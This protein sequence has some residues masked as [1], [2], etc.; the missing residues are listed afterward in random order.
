MGTPATG[1]LDGESMD[2]PAGT[3]D[4]TAVDPLSD[5]DTL[6]EMVDVGKRYGSELAVENVSLSVVDGE[7]LTL[8]GPSGCGKTT[9]L[10]LI[11]GL[12]RP[13]S[14]TIRID[15]DRVAGDGTFHPPERRGV[16]VVFQGFA[17]FP[18]LTAEENVA[19]GLDGWS[20]PDRRRRVEELFDLVD[21]S[22]HRDDYPS[23]LSGGQQ[24]RVAL[25]RSLAPE[26]DVL[27]LDEPFSNLDVDLRIRMREQVRRILTE[28]GTTAISV[29]HD[30]EEALSISDRVAVMHDGAIEQVD[31][32]ESLYHRPRSRFVAEFLGETSFLTGY[33]HGD[34]VATPLE[35]LPRDRLHGLDP[36]YDETHIDVLIRPDDVLATA[37]TPEP[38]N[39]T[40]TYRQYRGSTVVFR[41]ELDDGGRIECLHN[42]VDPLELGD[43]VR[44]EL[45]AEHDLAWF[46]AGT[47]DDHVS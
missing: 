32:P 20:G 17:L 8:L 1:S 16:G 18:H 42:H 41:V 43:S 44:V 27:L 6:V 15:G 34:E 4:G 26:P 2:D 7:L 11:A 37:G 22:E 47:A 14:G 29:T 45:V 33:V 9:T 21:L 38:C 30:Q 3:R 36:A 19:F 39:G 40:I 23:E 24:Q 5:D 31:R 10:R 35:T 46:P 28:T 12:D 25:A 13:T